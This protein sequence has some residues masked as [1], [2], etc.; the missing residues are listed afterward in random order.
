MYSNFVNIFPKRPDPSNYIFTLSSWSEFMHCNVRVPQTMSD[1]GSRHLRNSAI[2]T[3]NLMF[4]G[5]DSTVQ[6]S[7]AN[8][9]SSIQSTKGHHF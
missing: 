8:E 3:L 2:I 1:R 4:I 7:T 9:T 5:G 6:Y